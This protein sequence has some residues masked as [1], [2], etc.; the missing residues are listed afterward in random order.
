ML[1]EAI[2][3]AQKPTPPFWKKVRKAGIVLAAIG[4][5]IVT[6]VMTGGIAAPAWLTTLGYVL[7]GA[8]ATMATTA[9]LAVDE[10]PPQVPQPPKLQK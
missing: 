7:A 6:T 9:S 2:E 5:G 8:G 3:R 1:K 10:E 4:T